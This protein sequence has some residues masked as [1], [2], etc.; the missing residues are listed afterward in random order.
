MRTVLQALR[1]LVEPQVVVDGPLVLHEPD[2]RS[3]CPPTKIEQSGRQA[4]ALRFEPRRFRDGPTLPINEWLFPLLDTT[5]SQPPICRSCDYII[6]YAPRDEQREIFVFLCELK[7][8]SAKGGNAQ[9]R[10]GLLLARYLME[11]IGLYGEVPDPWPTTQYRGIIFLGSGPSRRDP[12]KASTAP[13]YVTDKRT[14][15][16]VTVERAGGG[17]HLQRFCL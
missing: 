6:F 2:D 15:L 3:T 9:L 4:V 5:R 13:D 17:H 8:R 10:N 11:V 16:S 1:E 12:L 14:K 7:S